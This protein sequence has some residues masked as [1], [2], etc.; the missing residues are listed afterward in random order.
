MPT[1]HL[2]PVQ[3]TTVHERGHGFIE[4]NERVRRM[5]TLNSLLPPISATPTYTTTHPPED[6]KCGVRRRERPRRL[7]SPTLCAHGLDTL[8]ISVPLEQVTILQ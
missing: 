5:Y 2:C 4:G 6:N 7:V 8:V 3:F 1:H